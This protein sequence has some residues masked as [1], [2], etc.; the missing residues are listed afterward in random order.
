MIWVVTNVEKTRDELVSILQAKGYVAEHIACVD[1]VPDR[2]LFRCPALMI[3]DCTVEGS[4]DLVSAMRAEPR[5][6]TV[7]LIV[8]ATSDPSHQ[9]EALARGADA[10]ILKRTL[11]WAEL[12]PAIVNLVGP[13]PGPDRA[14]ASR[15]ADRSD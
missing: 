7:P 8:F 13:P 2:A 12:L 11:D 6:C 1:G 3:I 10:F 5:T 14:D 9:A 4:F 15:A